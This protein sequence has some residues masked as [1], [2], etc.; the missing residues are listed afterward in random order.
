MVEEA[1]GEVV[2]G[3]VPIVG[4]VVGEGCDGVG[5]VGVGGFH[6]AVGVEG[7]K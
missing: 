6:E 3:L 2:E 5:D 7:E 4:E 1:V